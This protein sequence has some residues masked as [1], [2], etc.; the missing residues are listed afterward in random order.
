MSKANSEDPNKMPQNAAFK[1]I[2]FVIYGFISE[3]T[4]KGHFQYHTN[5]K[6]FKRGLTCIQHNFFH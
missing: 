6:G 3:F 5:L 4:D 2:Y 1:G